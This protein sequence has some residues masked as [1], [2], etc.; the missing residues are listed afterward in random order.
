MKNKNIFLQKNISFL[1]LA[2]LGFNYSAFLIVF[3]LKALPAFLMQLIL[4]LNVLKNQ[5]G[6][7]QLII[8][9]DLYM[10]FIAGL[11]V[12]FLWFK[13]WKSIYKSVIGYYKTRRVLKNLN[14]Y[15]VDEVNV[16]NTS[17]EFVFTTGLI[18]PKIYISQKLLKTF[19]EEEYKVVIAHEKYHQKSFDSLKK[20]VLNII[21]SMLLYFPGKKTLFENY[22]VLTELCADKH[23]EGISKS[24]KP[25]VSAL[26]KMVEF[27]STN[28]TNISA[29]NLKSDRIKILVG[30]ELFKT[31][32]F[33]TAL[34]MIITFTFFN[35]LLIKNTDVFMQCQHIVECFQALFSENGKISS[36][37]K[38]VCLSSDN[39]TS[40]YHCMKFNESHHPD[41]NSMMSSL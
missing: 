41:D 32:S 20:F 3:T 10:G 12:I 27:S 28:L 36:Q 15:F 9:L 1:L 34:F 22:D 16:V 7:Q 35:T 5:S 2:F 18:N 24:R 4:L 17:D 6:L 14:C 21:Y 31:K 37:D 25:I 13:F 39:L 30:K 33:F 8:T 19:S 23:A 38:E 40:K 26:S 29:F 11:L